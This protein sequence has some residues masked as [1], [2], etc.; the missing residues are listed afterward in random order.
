MI[1]Y[2]NITTGI[3]SDIN[4]PEN[5]IG[6]A[7]HI[8]CFALDERYHGL[9]QAIDNKGNS[10]KLSDIFF[11]QCLTCIESLREKIGFSFITLSSTN[12]GYNLYKRAAFEDME[13][14]MLIAEKNMGQGGCRPMY[15]ALDIEDQSK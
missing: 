12:D 15:Y 3:I 9:W 1:G 13:D 2:Y 14:D 10:V 6:G 7:A 11:H 8:N 4:N 5:R